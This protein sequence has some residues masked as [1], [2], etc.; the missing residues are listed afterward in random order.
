MSLAELSTEWYLEDFNYRII[1]ATA[2]NDKIPGEDTR[3][4]RVSLSH[5]LCTP[6]LLQGSFRSIK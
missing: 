3:Y 5:Q 2:G 6:P 4:L 1:Y